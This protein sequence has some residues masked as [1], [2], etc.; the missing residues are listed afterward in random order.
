MDLTRFEDFRFRTGH[1]FED[2]LRKLAIPLVQ[3][4]G[5]APGAI[6]WAPTASY[7]PW[8]PFGC[9]GRA[10]WDST[11]IAPRERDLWE[12]PTNGAGG[13]RTKLSSTLSLPPRRC[14][15]TRPGTRWLKRAVYVAVFFV[16]TSPF[17]DGN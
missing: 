15:P 9:R 4:A 6:G 2:A 16:G 13:E 14:V 12:L 8:T 3:R 1:A 10:R 5:R 17:K 11:L 7:A